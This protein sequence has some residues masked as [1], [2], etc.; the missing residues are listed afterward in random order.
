MPLQSSD[1]FLDLETLKGEVE[2]DGD[3]LNEEH[4]KLCKELASVEAS[5]KRLRSQNKDLTQQ[6]ME[7]TT[8]VSRQQVQIR[9]Q[10]SEI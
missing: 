3:N 5:L 10:E 9:N 7:Q 1:L 4:D 8:D 6:I 2:L